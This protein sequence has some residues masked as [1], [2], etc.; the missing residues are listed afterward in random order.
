MD[1]HSI[2]LNDGKLSACGVEFRRVE[3]LKSK[4]E[5]GGYCAAL[6]AAIF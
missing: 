6:F 3:V 1:G 4:R 5:G 2:F